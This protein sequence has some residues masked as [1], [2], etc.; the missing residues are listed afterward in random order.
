M[1]PQKQVSYST[2]NTYSTLNTITSETKH[3]W[4]V[5][6]GLGYL[7]KYF[8]N[9]FSEL[10]PTENFI[11][12]PQAPAKYYQDKKFRH[13]GASWL[14]RE[15][16]TL[17]IENVLN[18]IDAVFDA[19]KPNTLPNFIVLGYSQ[20]VSIATRWVASRKIKCNHLI[21]HSG[22]IPKELQPEDFTFMSPTT[23]VTY[24]YGDNDPYI[25][26]ARKTEEELKGSN[27][28]GERLEVHVFKGVHEV[29]KEF[30]ITTAK[31]K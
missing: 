24:L 15:N 29:N 13:V 17:E 31:E 7:S 21:L 6:H 10:N 1:T 14:T 30:L 27:L 20:G 4:L 28:F 26:E 23:K 16:T 19:E 11:I 12:A 5:F 25:T 8:I 3:I 22:G 2:T 18:Y 9:Y